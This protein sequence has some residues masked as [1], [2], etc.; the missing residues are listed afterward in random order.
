MEKNKWPTTV[1][2]TFVNLKSNTMKNI[3]EDAHERFNLLNL[4]FQPINLIN[5]KNIMECALSQWAQY[6]E[7]QNLSQ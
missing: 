7:R 1:S 3:S 6:Y 4:N 2:R 5:Y